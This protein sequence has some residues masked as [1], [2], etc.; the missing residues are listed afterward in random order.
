MVSGLDGNSITV[1]N[2]VMVSCDA[3]AIGTDMQVGIGES[4]TTANATGTIAIAATPAVAGH[5]FSSSAHLKKHKSAGYHYYAMLESNGTTSGTVTWYGD[6]G[7]PLERQSG[8]SA[9]FRM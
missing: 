1:D 8:I 7:A 4:N 3:V 2:G 6:N 5:I 9:I